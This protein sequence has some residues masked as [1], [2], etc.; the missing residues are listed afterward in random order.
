ML[1]FDT[2][3]FLSWLTTKCKLEASFL[4]CEVKERVES[5][6]TPRWLKFGEEVIGPKGVSKSRVGGSLFWKSIILVLLLKVALF[7]N[8]QLWTRLVMSETAFFNCGRFLRSYSINIVQS[9]AKAWHWIPC[10]LRE[11]R[12]SSMKRFHRKGERTAP[13]GVDRL[14]FVWAKPLPYVSWEV[15]PS[16]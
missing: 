3:Y 8:P 11:I 5:K 16:R 1:R 4:M 2:A 14:S 6:I 15:L 10:L 9:S 7:C 13:W 12:R